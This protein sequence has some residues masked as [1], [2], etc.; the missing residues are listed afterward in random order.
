MIC[1]YMRSLTVFSPDVLI[2]LILELTQNRSY[3]WIYGEFNMVKT[4]NSQ[5]AGDIVTILLSAHER[6]EFLFCEKRA[7]S[8]DLSQNL[9]EHYF[10]LKE[11]VS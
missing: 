11:R 4:R 3:R 8:H 2:R 9:Q 7:K 5:S 6:K 1:D 10:Q